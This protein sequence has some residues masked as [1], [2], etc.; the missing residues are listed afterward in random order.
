M[1]TTHPPVVGLTLNYRHA[2]RTLRCVQSLLDEGSAHVLVWDNSDDAGASTGV[3][4]ESLKGESRVSIERSPVNLGFSAGVNRG[5]AWITAR[6]GKTWVLLLNN[7]AQLS[8]G[9]I[10]SLT[11]ALAEGP[12]AVISY[13]DIDHAGDIRGTTYY[14]RH[15]GLLTRKPLPGSLPHASGCCLLIAPERMG[16]KLFDED[17]FMYG[18]DAE[19]GARLGAHAMAHVP[20][21]LVYHEGSVSSGLGTEFYEVHMVAAHWILARKLALNPQD[22]GL[23]LTVRLF[24]LSLRAVLRAFRYRSIIPL[25]ALCRGWRIARAQAR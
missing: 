25:R 8:P 15:T 11:K 7:D 10:S 20:E 13:P 16:A 14:Q 21:T 24:T 17:F 6:F 3:L 9:A 22:S 5:I 19:L 2:S 4:A 1:M 12:H 18:E 23:L